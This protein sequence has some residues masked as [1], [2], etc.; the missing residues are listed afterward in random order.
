[1]MHRLYFEELD[2]EAGTG[3]SQ[4]LFVMQPLVFQNFAYQNCPPLSPSTQQLK[5][6]CSADI[7]FDI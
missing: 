5:K 3:V 2:V 7:S 4:S 1:M 6:L